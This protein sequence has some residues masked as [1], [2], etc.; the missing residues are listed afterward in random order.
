MQDFY[1]PG[2]W[3][4]YKPMP[5]Y[6]PRHWLCPRKRDLSIQSSRNECAVQ[7]GSLH[8]ITTAGTWWK[9]A[10]WKKTTVRLWY[11]TEVL[12]HVQP[13]ATVPFSD[14]SLQHY[15]ANCKYYSSK[16]QIIFSPLEI[17]TGEILLSLIQL[18]SW[19]FRSRKVTFHW[20]TSDWLK[21]RAR[22]SGQ[23]SLSHGQ[24]TSTRKWTGTKKVTPR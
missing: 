16:S 18:Q 10:K 7:T 3:Q 5:Q 2:L 14:H 6:W 22:C 23:W 20:L 11:P 4:R 1:K 9:A 19:G 12:I 13:V 15:D 8:M 21:Q 24:D 17:I